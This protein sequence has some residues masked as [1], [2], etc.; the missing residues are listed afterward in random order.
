LWYGIFHEFCRLGYAK[1]DGMVKQGGRGKTGK[2]GGRNGT[3]IAPPP[4]MSLLQELLSFVQSLRL[5]DK[6][7]PQR[8]PEIIWAYLFFPVFVAYLMILTT[9]INEKPTIGQVVMYD[10][11][12]NSLINPSSKIEIIATGFNWTE[13]PL[14]MADDSMPYLLFSDTVNN[15]IFKW[16]EGKGMF[17]IGKTLFMQSSGCRDNNCANFYEPGTN[18]LLRKDDTSKDIIACSHGERSLL[19]LRENGTRTAIVSHYKGKR[20]NSPND[21][22]W[23]PDG[24]LYFTDPDYGLQDF[25]HIIQ[26]KELEHNGV[27]MVKGDYL[28]LAMELGQ[29][30]AYVRLVETKLSKPNGLAFSPDFSKLYIS[31]S[32]RNSPFINVYDVMD[33]GSLKNGALFFN[34]SSLFKQECERAG[35][36]ENVGSPDGL[37]VDIHGNIFATGPGGILV[38]S[39]EGKLLGMLRLDR[40]VS[41]LAFGGDG[42]LYA[43]AKDIVVRLRVATK[44]AR[45]IKKIR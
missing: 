35:S 32:D 21:V 27:Y 13:G 14:W 15:N 9:F 10:P 28:R 44:P 18:G 19:L 34:A 11:S 25:Q 33:D 5:G 24:H 22:V 45:I 3:I 12:F 42:R 2:A 41:N 40:P 43:T 16:E 4:S 23:S 31:N 38:I 30:T 26:D 29:P 20:L 17:T 36:C 6:L 37:K 39:P 8:N 7:L 1:Y